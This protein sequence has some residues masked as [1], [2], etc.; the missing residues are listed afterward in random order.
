MRHDKDHPDG[1]LTVRYNPDLDRNEYWSWTAERWSPISVRLSDEEIKLT[2]ASTW[3]EPCEG[4]T[5][6]N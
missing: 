2:Y 6:E 5:D 4:V 1:R 3:C